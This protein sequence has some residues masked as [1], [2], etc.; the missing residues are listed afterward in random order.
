VAYS[1]FGWFLI[2]TTAPLLVWIVVALFALIQALLLT[3]LFDGLRDFAR[4]WLR[5]DLGYFTL[6]MISALG[7]TFALVWF[8][9]FG[10]FLM[11]VAAEILT[12]LD[13]QNSGF[14]RLQSLLILTLVSLAGLAVGWVVSQNSLF[15]P[16]I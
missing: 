12:R 6:I 8:K 5:S 4:R 3:T 15:R 1:S 13:L 16:V 7:F 2:K 9:T 10:Y 14:S 11:L